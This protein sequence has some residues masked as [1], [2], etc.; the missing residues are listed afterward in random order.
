MTF[1]KKFEKAK[2]TA[3]ESCMKGLEAEVHA[4]VAVAH[5]S[6][7]ASQLP[8]PSFGNMSG[9]RGVLKLM[10]VDGHEGFDLIA[11]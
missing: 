6:S 10:R 9:A 4:A 11:S 7:A 3:S 5:S 1:D 2:E 8:Y